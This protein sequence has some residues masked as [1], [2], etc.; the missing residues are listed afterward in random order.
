VLRYT[1]LVRQVFK[2]RIKKIKESIA[3]MGRAEKRK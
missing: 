3:R 1:H 2:L